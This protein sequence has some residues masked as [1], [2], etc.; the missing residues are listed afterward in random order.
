[1]DAGSGQ[2]ISKRFRLPT[3]SVYYLFSRFK[4]ALANRLVAGN[5][6]SAIHMQFMYWVTILGPIA[7]RRQPDFGF[8]KQKE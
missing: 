4:G 5:A 8:G 3:K 6:D 2:I 1:V 7:Y